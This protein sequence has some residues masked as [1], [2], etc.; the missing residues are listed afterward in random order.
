VLAFILAANVISDWFAGESGRFKYLVLSR[1]ELSGCS[2]A[3]R[4]KDVEWC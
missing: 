4:V 1:C 3:D 2:G